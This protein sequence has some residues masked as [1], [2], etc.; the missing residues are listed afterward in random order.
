MHKKSLRSWKKVFRGD[1][2]YI[3]YELKELTQKPALFILEGD[4]G[5]GKTTF[6][7]NFVDD[8]TL[9]SSPSYSIVSDYGRI[10]HADFYRL[11]NR[12]DIIHLELALYLEDK[13]YF[14]AEW[15]LKHYSGLCME[16]PEEMSH[17]LITIEATST[18]DGSDENTESPRNFE[19]F[20]IQED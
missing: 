17:Y 4:L 11:E 9:T 2:S 20:E 19:L 8:D 3:S 10:L 7:K 13:D 1:L 6:V 15:A 12:E 18:L 5:A 16:L 14:F